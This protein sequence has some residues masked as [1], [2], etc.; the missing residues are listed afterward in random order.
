MVRSR[1]SLLL[2]LFLVGLP[3]SG[4]TANGANRFLG[5]GSGIPAVHKCCPRDQALLSGRGC[6]R[7]SSPPSAYLT[8][9]QNTMS[10]R[11]GFPVPRNTT[12]TMMMLRR[13]I[14]HVATWWI[15]R[16][17][18]LAVEA[19]QGELAIHNYC[20][21]DLVDPVTNA[22]SPSAVTC[23]HELNGELQLP[24]S[25][26]R[27]KTVGKCCARDQHFSHVN[28][29]CQTG[30]EGIPDWEVPVPG[31]DNETQLGYTGFPSCSS[32]K[33]S[34]YYFENNTKE[35]V[36]LSA[37]L[38]LLIV[39]M[40]GHCVERESTV[41]L[42]DYC[43]DYEWDGK[44]EAKPLAVVCLE[45]DD[46]LDL[47]EV[48]Q[49][50][51]LLVLLS[52]SC[53]ALILTLI[54]L[55]AL[56]AKGFVQ[57][58]SQTDLLAPRTHI[59]YVVAMLLSFFVFAAA[60]GLDAHERSSLCKA[61]GG[62]LMFFIL[63]GFHWNTALCIE[64]LLIIMRYGVTGWAR[65]A[66]HCCW[67]WGI[68]AAI[69]FVAMSLDAHSDNLSCSAILP[70]IGKFKCFFSDPDAYM[71]YLYMPIFATLVVNLV[72][73]WA[74]RRIRLMRLRRLELGAKHH[75]KRH[76]SS[77]GSGNGK[78]GTLEGDI[79]APDLQRRALGPAYSSTKGSNSSIARFG[80]SSRE[81]LKLWLEAVCLAL[82]SAVTV[83][84]EV[85]GFTVMGYGLSRGDQWHQSLWYIPTAVNALRGLG[86][87]LILVIL[88]KESR[89]YAAELISAAWEKCGGKPLRELL[90]STRRSSTSTSTTATTTATAS[91]VAL[92]D[93]ERISQSSSDTPLSSHTASMSELRE[94]P[95]PNDNGF[96]PTTLETNSTS[97]S[98]KPKSLPLEKT[99]DSRTPKKTNSKTDEKATN[100]GSI[101]KSDENESDRKSDKLSSENPD[102]Y[103]RDETMNCMNNTS[104]DAP[105]TDVE[106]GCLNESVR[107]ISEIY[108]KRNSLGMPA[109][110]PRKSLDLSTRASLSLENVSQFPGRGDSRP[111][112]PPKTPSPSLEDDCNSKDPCRYP[113][114]IRSDSAPDT[115]PDSVPPSPPKSP[116]PLEVCDQILEVLP[117]QTVD[118]SH[119]SIS[120]TRSVKNDDAVKLKPS[121]YSGI[122]TDDAGSTNMDET[123]NY[124]K[125]LA[126]D[127]SCVVSPEKIRK[128]DD[129]RL[130]SSENSMARAD[131][132]TNQA[133]NPSAFFNQASYDGE[134]PGSEFSLD[135]KIERE[136]ADDCVAS[137]GDNDSEH[138]PDAAEVESCKSTLNVTNISA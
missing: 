96:T 25:S 87:F 74:G 126:L 114:K 135:D 43:F 1:V 75:H 104:T 136:K 86:V 7:S 27:S 65:Y 94:L 120:A 97:I 78:N 77:G 17:G 10:V 132:S 12:C 133:E 29:T 123:E 128:K 64:S 116:P 20:L 76:A 51:A 8:H 42:K 129:S 31:A 63:A 3:N 93:K 15:S 127:N 36:R 11:V 54:F 71:L 117:L 115:P 44:R 39:R 137:R 52:L 60:S 109:K 73:L 80:L 85:I 13:D 14:K 124:K 111:A 9:L 90:P 59:T 68:P 98:T 103:H 18:L 113:S 49:Q 112:T 92:G 138:H 22:A 35:H 26:F 110:P 95:N 48:E 67:A 61:T 38:S 72:T 100:G 33:Y 57:H 119:L 99:I 46:V 118:E 81:T 125:P 79:S 45:P 89:S 32:G 16:V 101:S 130:E 34:T 6:I 55:V 70:R 107:N 62:F 88:P 58:E 121:E 2:T 69:T 28:R 53:I 83:T 84:L 41:S 37:N 105:M 66:L 50:P 91:P 131:A 30:A 47:L 106:H 108:P 5:R 122:A 24:L 23:V 19:P 21:D 40:N 82:W 56:Q 134:V 102:I 4:T